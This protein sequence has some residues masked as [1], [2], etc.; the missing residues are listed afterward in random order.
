VQRYL[1]G[2]ANEAHK[3]SGS[4]EDVV[5][6]RDFTADQAKDAARDALGA[7]APVVAG[8]PDRVRAVKWDAIFEFDA[9][10][11]QRVM[12]DRVKQAPDP[13]P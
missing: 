7:L 8:Q 12:S 10:P 11:G 2:T 1:P 3:G 6:L 5:V 13:L 4:W 9:A